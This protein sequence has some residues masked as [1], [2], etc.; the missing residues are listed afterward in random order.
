[1]NT[2]PPIYGLPAEI[3]QF[4]YHSSLLD[5]V[6]VLIIEVNKILLILILTERPNMIIQFIDLRLVHL[7]SY[8]LVLLYLL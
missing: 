5:E 8:T 3:P 7:L 2:R 6:V 1:M 4:S